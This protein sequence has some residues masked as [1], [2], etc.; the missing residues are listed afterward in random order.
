MVYRYSTFADR[1]PDRVLFPTQRK[2]LASV[3]C[4]W[5]VGAVR[6][7]LRCSPPTLLGAEM[8]HHFQSKSR[9]CKGL[10][11]GPEGVQPT[12]VVEAHYRECG[13]DNAFRDVTKL[14]G[15]ENELGDTRFDHPGPNVLAQKPMGA[16]S[17]KD[18]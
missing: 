14:T 3:F 4:P 5:E 9:Q 17:S 16:T 15:N 13:E 12:P 2:V 18:Y 10:S 1:S 7:L 8:L 6:S 11:Q